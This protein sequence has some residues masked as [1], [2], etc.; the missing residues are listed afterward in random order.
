MAEYITF[1][2]MKNNSTPLL[3]SVVDS[4]TVID[5][6]A[7]FILGRSGVYSDTHVKGVRDTGANSAGTWACGSTIAASAD[8]G[9]A[10]SFDL[11]TFGDSYEICYSVAGDAKANEENRRALIAARNVMEYTMAAAVS[12]IE[13]QTASWNTSTAASSAGFQRTDLN[14]LIQSVKLK[15]Q[16]SFVFFG[17]GDS[18][19]QLVEDIQGLG[20]FNYTEVQGMV[21]PVYRGIPILTSDHASAGT[22]TAVDF[23]SYEGYFNLPAGTPFNEFLAMDRSMHPTEPGT[24]YRLFTMFGSVLLS[25]RASAQKTLV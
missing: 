14:A 17:D 13:T 11:E 22:L 4:A 25:T 21:L 9:S 1:A 15:N 20:G 18:V 24:I 12:D 19:N 2:Q 3:R 7:P 5:E 16:G 10:Y 23:G 6:L 8:P